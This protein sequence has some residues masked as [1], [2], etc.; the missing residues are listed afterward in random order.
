[1]YRQLFQLIGSKCK[2]FY[3]LPPFQI[4]QSDKL[5]PRPEWKRQKHAFP[6]RKLLETLQQNEESLLPAEQEEDWWYTSM[7][8]NNVHSDK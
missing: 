4:Y 3:Q 2:L 6:I 1:M 7:S 5:L 8:W